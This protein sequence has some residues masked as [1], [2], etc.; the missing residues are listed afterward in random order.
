MNPTFMNYCRTCKYWAVN[1]HKIGEGCC[2]NVETYLHQNSLQNSHQVAQNFGC[3]LHEPGSCTCR[4][5]PPEQ[6]L[7]E[8]RAFL[9]DRHGITLS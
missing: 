3:P 2:I 5:Y 7:V 4:I 6:E 9:K 8:I 1:A